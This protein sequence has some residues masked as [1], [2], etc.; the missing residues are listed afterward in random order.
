MRFSSSRAAIAALPRYRWTKT[1]C[2]LVCFGRALRAA[3]LLFLALVFMCDH[4]CSRMRTTSL[5]DY[6][7][8]LIV[9][10]ALARLDWK[11]EFLAPTFEC[12]SLWAHRSFVEQALVN[13]GQRPMFVDVFP[14]ERQRL[15]PLPKALWVDA[16]FA[17]PPFWS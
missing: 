5:V 10:L 9:R 6:P 1:D 17:G 2:G 11:T 13:L 12:L 14:Q 8:G 16:V 7:R 3:P 15:R 4:P